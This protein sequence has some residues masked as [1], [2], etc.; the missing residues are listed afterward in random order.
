MATVSYT[1]TVN[2]VGSAVDGSETSGTQAY[3]SLTDT[4]GSFSAK[5]FYLPALAQNQMLAVA[6]AAI[7]TGKKV[8][9]GAAAAPNSANNPYTE[10]TRLILAP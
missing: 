10:I 9:V 4:A 6:L 5:F 2:N 3:V 7:T 1:C 8:W